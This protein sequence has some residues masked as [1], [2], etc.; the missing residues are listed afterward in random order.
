MTA[1]S[2]DPPAPRRARPPWYRRKLTLEAR[3]QGALLMVVATIVVFFIAFLV[4]CAVAWRSR[5]EDLSAAGAI[6]G[7]TDWILIAE[8]FGG[9]L[10]LSWA[11]LYAVNFYSNR[12]FGPIWR[13]HE[14]MKRVL[15]GGEPR[16]IAL[17]PEDS[18]PEFAET[19]NRLVVELH[20]LRRN[21]KR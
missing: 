16:P 10:L 2:S 3:G 6:A 4:G 7:A 12:I 14:D 5:M 1:A 17:R 8:V 21:A 11:S 19:Y 9:A 15:D 20:S 18:F 13:M